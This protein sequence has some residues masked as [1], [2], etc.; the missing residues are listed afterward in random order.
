M[1]WKKE[2]VMKRKE[3]TPKQNVV[4]AMGLTAFAGMA[5]GGWAVSLAAYT[6]DVFQNWNPKMW[7]LWVLPTVMTWGMIGAVLWQASIYAKAAIDNA[8]NQNLPS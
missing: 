7:E 2:R 4:I 1:V 5:L 3:Y 6:I 8:H